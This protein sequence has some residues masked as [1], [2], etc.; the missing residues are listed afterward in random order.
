VTREAE[1]AVTVY[2]QCWGQISTTQCTANLLCARYVCLYEWCAA[3]Y[4]IVTARV[5][6]LG[7]LWAV[8]FYS[9]QTGSQFLLG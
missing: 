2:G 3:V 1:A 5:S 9:M 8:C 4:T 7:E 6:L